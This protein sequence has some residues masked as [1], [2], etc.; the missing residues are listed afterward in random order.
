MDISIKESVLFIIKFIKMTQIEHIIELPR[1][2]QGGEK[3][4]KKLLIG[5]SV[6]K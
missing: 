3:R 4:T 5:K 2:V 6:K 1:S